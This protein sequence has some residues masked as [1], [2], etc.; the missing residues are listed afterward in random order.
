MHVLPEC[1]IA[2]AHSAEE[3][4]QGA[5]LLFRLLVAGHVD[6]E[7]WGRTGLFSLEARLARRR[8]REGSVM[9]TARWRKA[10][11]LSHSGI[12]VRAWAA[13]VIESLRKAW[14]RRHT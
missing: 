12:P 13:L 2:L 3:G 11:V 1:C 4:G 9:L 7:M 5:V 8:S 6:R 10:A 14:S